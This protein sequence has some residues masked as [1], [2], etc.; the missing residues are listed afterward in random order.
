MIFGSFTDVILKNKLNTSEFY[1]ALNQGLKKVPLLFNFYSSLD[2]ILMFVTMISSLLSSLIY[3]FFFIRFNTINIINPISRLKESME[4]VSNNDLTAFTYVETADEIDQMVVG[5]N[6]MVDGLNEKEK[7]RDLF[8]QYLTKEISDKIIS[9]QIHIDGEIYY[10]TILFSDIRDF[11]RL[12][13]NISPTEIVAFLNEYFDKMIEVAVKYDGIIDKFIG[14]GMLV[15]FGIPIRIQDHATK[16][17]LA[18]I[19]MQKEIDELNKKRESEGKFPIKIGIGLH[20]GTILAGNIGNKRKLQYTVIGDTVNTASRIESL[21]KQFT[22]TILLSEE[23][24][25]NLDLNLFNLEKFTLHKDVE[26]RGKSEKFNLY[27]YQ[28]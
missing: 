28:S 12:T 19:E 4:R 18:S 7:I 24:Y 14:D 6:K 20:S 1:D 8:G 17:L 11:T 5:F 21:N 10:S 25:R 27:S 16:A 3:I 13:E 26:I 9:G 22:S 23:T 15:V 2:T